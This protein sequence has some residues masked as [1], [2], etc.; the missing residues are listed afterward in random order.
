MGWN[1]KYLFSKNEKKYQEKERTLPVT[2][3]F[4]IQFMEID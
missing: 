1:V 2:D 3:C 4:K